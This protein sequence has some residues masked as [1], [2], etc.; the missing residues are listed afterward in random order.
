MHTYSISSPHPV[1][2]DTLLGI[3]A[4]YPNVRPIEIYEQNIAQLT[5]N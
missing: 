3:V 4:C 2:T 5:M 1:K